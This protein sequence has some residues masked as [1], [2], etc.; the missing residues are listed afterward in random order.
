MYVRLEHFESGSVI[1]LFGD[2]K[3]HLGSIPYYQ[4]SHAFRSKSDFKTLATEH[5]TYG[6]KA[7]KELF[8]YFQNSRTIKK[9]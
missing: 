7:L 3:N 4:K 2:N 1:T 6:D 9:V 5:K 8:T